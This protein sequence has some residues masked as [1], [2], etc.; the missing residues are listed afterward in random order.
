MTTPAPPRA[1]S[2]LVLA[3]VGWLAANALILVLAGNTLPFHWTEPRATIGRLV[4]ANLALLEVFVLMAVVYAMTRKRDTTVFTERAPPYAVARRETLT[5]VAYGAA[6]L[7]GGFVLGR[8]AGWHPIGFHLAGTLHGTDD[9]VTPAEAIGWAAYNLIVYAALPLIYFRPR[10]STESLFLKSTDRRGDVLVIIVVLLIE[11]IAQYFA[12]HPQTFTLPPRQLALGA[13]LTF[14]L[15]F[16]GTCVPAMI[17]IYAILVPRY[18]RVTGS[19][20]TTVILGGVTYT[21][22]HLW[23]AWLVFASPTAAVVSILFLFL[24][25]L[26]PGMIKT[27]LTVRTGNAWVHLWAYHAFAPHT[28]LDTPLIVRVF[29]IT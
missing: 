22:L 17:F 13:P 11:S 18:L 19:V 10:Y 6:G 3:I 1:Q 20:T 29:R 15:Y 5:L 12:L 7:V 4:G 28:L 23:D 27:V 24:Q 25:Y 9:A 26:G 14:A 21:V 8:A 16:A 2:W